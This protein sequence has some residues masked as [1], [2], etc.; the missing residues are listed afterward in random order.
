MIRYSVI[1]PEHD[2]PDEVRRQLPALTAAL[3]RFNHPYEIIIVDDGSDHSALRLLQK[4]LSEFPCCRLLR[5]DQSFGVSVALTAGIQ[6]ARGEIVIAIESGENYKPEQI[7]QLVEGLQRADIMLGRRRQIGIAKAWHRISRLPRWLLLGLDG[8]D[9]DCLFWAARREVFADIN[10][11]PGTARYLPAL[12]A[13]RGFRACEMYVEHIGPHRAL[14]DI[15]PNLGDLLATWWHCRRW[16]PSAAHEITAGRTS[17]PLLRIVGEQSAADAADRA[18][19]VF[20][21]DQP[22]S[23]S[24]DPVHHSPVVKHA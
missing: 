1:I 9:P 10:L 15:R 4:L 11:A 22:Q 3:D 2:R 18:S 16:R 24:A 19:P 6:S 12:V 13:R 23:L 20:R 14:Q 21:I 5:L 8:H 7:A 17:Q